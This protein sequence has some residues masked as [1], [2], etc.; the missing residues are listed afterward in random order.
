MKIDAK[1][2]KVTIFWKSTRN[3][4]ESNVYESI[5]KASKSQMADE[6]PVENQTWTNIEEKS[7]EH[8]MSTKIGEESRKIERRR[9][10]NVDEKL[11]KVD[12]NQMSTNIDDRSTQIECR[13]ETKVNEKSTKNRRKSNAAEQQWDI[14]ENRMS[15]KIDKSKGT[16]DGNQ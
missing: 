13:R 11:L 5:R 16:V 7:H 2:V 14:E 4:R 6:K 3:R 10:S 15:T 12:E 8:R 9:K 1:V